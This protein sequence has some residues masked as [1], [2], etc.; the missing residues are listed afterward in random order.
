MTA[1]VSGDR[2]V[3]TDSDT[4]QILNWLWRGSPRTDSLVAATAAALR[5]LANGQGPGLAAVDAVRASA[6][7][8]QQWVEDNPCPDQRMGDRCEVFVARYRFVCLEMGSDR[9]RLPPDHIEVMI[10]RLATL[11]V[12][13]EKF[14]AQPVTGHGA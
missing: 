13:F 8:L 12:E 5:A 10:D 7:S 6:L 11:N 1:D 2:G 14:L 4:V 3:E 9:M